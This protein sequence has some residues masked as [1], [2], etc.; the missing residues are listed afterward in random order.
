LYSKKNDEVLITRINTL[1]GQ[2]ALLSRNSEKNKKGKPETECLFGSSVG[3]ATAGSN[4]VM[5]ALT[6]LIE[7]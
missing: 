3:F 7:F 4:E 2:I 6:A 5:T 1:L